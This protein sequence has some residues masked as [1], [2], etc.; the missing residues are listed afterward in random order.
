[1]NEAGWDKGEY[2]NC[3]I[4]ER[5]CQKVL[6]DRRVRACKFTGSTEGGKKVAI[7]CA[8]NMKKGCFE[9]GGSDPFVVL[10]D[11]NM[12]AAVNAA[13]PSRMGNSGQTCNNAKRF[14]ITSSVYDEFRDRLIEKIKEKTVI[15]DPMDPRTNLGPLAM[16]QQVTRIKNQVNMAINDGGAKLTYGDLNYQ[17]RDPELANGNY[18]NTMLLENM[19]PNSEAYKEEFFGPVFNLFKVDSHKDAIELAN[20]SE[21]GLAS[22]VFTDDMVKAEFA[23]REL[24][25]GTVFINDMMVVSSEYPGGGIKGSG[26]GRESYSDGLYDMSN[27]K[28]IIRK[29]DQE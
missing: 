25:A 12:E 21:Y 17:M 6:A 28:T 16:K 29:K 3:F 22:T 26:Y 18:V 15:G 23:S 24:R 11:A 19:N 4:T 27:R 8:R 2:Q 5:Q 20:K 7:E 1:M 9:L 10:K 14:I 13:Y